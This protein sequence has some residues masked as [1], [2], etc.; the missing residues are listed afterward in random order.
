MERTVLKVGLLA[1]L[2]APPAGAAELNRSWEKL[3]E[4]VTVGKSVV[5]KLTTSGLQEE[6]KLL[7]IS[8]ESIT[9]RLDGKPVTIPRKDVFRVRYA[10][11]RRKHTLLGMAIGVGI[12]AS[13]AV[14]SGRDNHPH[15]YGG[16]A[17]IGA[18]VGVGPGA[19]VG[20]ALPIGPPLYEAPVGVRSRW[21]TSDLSGWT[22]GVGAACRAGTGGGTAWGG[23]R[24]VRPGGA[25]GV[26]P[27]G[28]G[29]GN[30]V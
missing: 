20:G 1:A 15:Q 3:V 30:T 19:A 9:L 13:W 6:G 7:S 17:V 2:A 23:A 26:A 5:V 10:N 16:R 25:E 28:F 29:V 24:T 14:L 12:A 21:A 22:S 27:S 4:S 18:I 11:I 8:A